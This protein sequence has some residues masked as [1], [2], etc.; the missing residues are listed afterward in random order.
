MSEFSKIAL[1]ARIEIE[2]QLL[3]RPLE[4]EGE[5][6]RLA[7]A[8]VLELLAP[9]V[10]EEALG[11]GGALVGQRQADEAAFLDGGNVVARRPVERGELLA[12]IE[13]AGLQAFELQRAVAV[14][15]VAQLVEIEAAAIDGQVLAPVI[16]AALVGDVGA[17]IEVGD[18]VGAGAERLVERRLFEGVRGVIGLRE[19]G[20]LGDDERQVARQLALELV[21]HGMGIDAPRLSR[22]RAASARNWDG[23]SPSRP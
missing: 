20:E 17:G 13:G 11:S 18:L 1:R 3:V 7:H 4:V 16:G 6:E 15:L 5:I 23:P 9:R 21:A 8:L 12:E 2:E 14:V 10:D 19:N 22:R